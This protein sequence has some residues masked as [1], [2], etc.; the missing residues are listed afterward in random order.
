MTTSPAD[1]IARACLD[2]KAGMHDAADAIAAAH[3]LDN[4]ETFDLIK[5]A[6]MGQFT[7]AT[8]FEHDAR[9]ARWRCRFRL[10]ETAK[11]KDADPEAD[12]D[13]ELPP[14][15][16]GVEII[17]GLPAVGTALVELARAYHDGAQLSGLSPEHLAKGLRGLRPTLSRNK[18]VATWRMNYDTTDTFKAG[19]PVT[20]TRGWLARVDVERVR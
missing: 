15:A 9:A 11:G 5:R 13:P 17:A 10:Y 3:N 18:G 19:S 16:P 1:D 2:I 6:L 12:S 14:D 7:G 8:S 20:R 4:V